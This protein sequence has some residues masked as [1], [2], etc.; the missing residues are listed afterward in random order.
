MKHHSTNLLRGMVH[1]MVR[2]PARDPAR[3][4]TTLRAREPDS[5][6]RAFQAAPLSRLASNGNEHAHVRTA[7]ILGYN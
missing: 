2:G 1:D 6:F 4:P 5:T 7:A 3:L